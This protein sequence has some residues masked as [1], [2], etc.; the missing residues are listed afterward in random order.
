MSGQTPGSRRVVLH[1]G[2]PKTGTTYLQ[3]VLAHHREALAAAGV[4]YPD[5]GPEAMFRAA[6]QV[7]G[8]HAL[9]GLTAEDVAGRWERLCAHARGHD[10]VTV[11]SHEILAGASGEEIGR[12]LAALDGIPVDVVVTTR[13]L[14]RLAT[15]FWQERV[16]LG[17]PWTFAALA[18]EQID[19]ELRGEVTQ[20]R[21]R[22]W[23][24][25]DLAETVRRWAGAVG[26]SRVH[27]V[28]GPPAGSP[29]GELWRRFGRAA[30]LPEGLADLDPAPGGGAAN[31]SLGRTQVAL[32]REVD[33]ALGTGGEE[34]GLAPR[35]RALVV[36]RHLAERV[37]PGLGER[38]PLLTPAE[39]HAPFAALTDRWLAELDGAGVDVVGDPGDLAPVCGEP[40]DPHPD[41]VDPER[42]AALA[43]AA[44]GAL[45]LAPPPA[46]RGPEAG[47]GESP[48]SR[49]PGLLRTW[50]RSRA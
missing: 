12:A 3:A 42:L 4:S 21:P 46:T 34:P 24:A 25:Y 20:P 33:A 47:G 30:G 36:K 18:A 37:L 38:E 8:S 14:G 43:C 9:F 39:Y 45:A 32:L 49:R 27:V 26:A 5:L 22:F 7:R 50:W 28:L 1:V 11:I 48:A 41:D 2:L 29:P 35:R 10:G 19:P 13:D 31:A 23:H 44:V 17:E 16:K 6:V 15:A 40:G